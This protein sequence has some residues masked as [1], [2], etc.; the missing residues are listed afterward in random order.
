[1]LSAFPLVLAGSEAAANVIAKEYDALPKLEKSKFAKKITAEYGWSQD[2]L[3]RFARVGKDFSDKRQIIL[4]GAH[5]VQIDEVSLNVMTEVVRT[6]D[7]T[8]KAAVKAG[9]FNNPVSA[10]NIRRFR[11]TGRLP[12]SASEILAVLSDFWFE[13]I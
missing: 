8:L 11:K 5:T 4:D 12:Q 1:M 13:P 6:T 9:L 10:E 7:E 2:R 3:N